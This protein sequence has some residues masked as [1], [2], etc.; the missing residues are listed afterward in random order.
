MSE[1]R[2]DIITNAAGTGTPDFSQGLKVSKVTT[3]PPAVNTLYKD[4]ICK[5]WINF[6]GTGV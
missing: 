1:L 4:N 3:S 5:A 6:N 2:T